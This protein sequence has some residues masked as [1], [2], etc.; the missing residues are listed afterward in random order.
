[1]DQNGNPVTGVSAVVINVT[2]TDTTAPSFLTLW[3]D[4]SAQPGSS[5]LNWVAGQTV[6]NLVVVK[7]GPDSAFDVYNSSGST[8]VII[9][10]VGIYG[11]PQPAPSGTAAVAFRLVPYRGR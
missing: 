8:D 10:L 3:P 9:D 6:P 11:G 5:D 1:V 7:L 2:V 4:G